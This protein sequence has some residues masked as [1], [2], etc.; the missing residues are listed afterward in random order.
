MLDRVHAM[1]LAMVM[2]A[3]ERTPAEIARTLNMTQGSLSQM[4]RRD[5][6]LLSTLRNCLA[7]TGA[8]NP[9]SV[10]PSRS[11]LI[12]VPDQAH[13]EASRAFGSSPT[14]QVNGAFDSTCVFCLEDGVPV[15][16]DPFVFEEDDVDLPRLLPHADAAK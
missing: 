13:A 16:G 5:D 12:F 15:E 9:S 3:R 10:D 1:C 11:K 4:E 8:E 14:S 6:M 2:E 7:A